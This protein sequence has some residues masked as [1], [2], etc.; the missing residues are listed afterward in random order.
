MR[1]ENRLKWRGCSVDTARGSTFSGEAQRDRAFREPDTLERGPEM[2]EQEKASKKTLTI[3]YRESP[4][5]RNVHVSGAYGGLTPTGEIF[6]G[7][8]SQRLHFPESS[9]V[10][11]PGN[12]GVA[13]EK[14]FKVSS[15]LVRDM[16]VGLT[17]DI[18]TAKAVYEWLKFKLEAAT[19][20]DKALAADRQG[21]G[22]K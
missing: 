5:Y 13:I 6:M 9:C 2:S 11:L 17:M 21:R 15:G 16:E 3:S 22:L 1:L 10:E 7:V 4:A 18:D 12:V 8:Y 14:D 19:E 20:R